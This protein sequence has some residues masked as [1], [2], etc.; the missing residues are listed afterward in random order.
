MEDILLRCHLDGAQIACM[1][2]HRATDMKCLARKMK[3]KAAPNA[4]YNELVLTE[5]IRSQHC[6]SNHWNFASHFLLK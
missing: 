4:I 6:S 1:V 5:A 3:D 2:F